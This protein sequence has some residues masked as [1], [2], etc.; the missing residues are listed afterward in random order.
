MGCIIGGTCI[1]LAFFVLLDVPD[2]S[3]LTQLEPCMHAHMY[4]ASV[5][6]HCKIVHNLHV[7]QA[8]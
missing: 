6:Q 8:G 4:I 5:S 1:E 7:L 2:K 3:F